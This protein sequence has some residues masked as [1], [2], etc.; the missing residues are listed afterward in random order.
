M[1]TKTTDLKKRRDELRKEEKISL[2]DDMPCNNLDIPFSTIRLPPSRDVITLDGKGPL[3]F[4]H[5]IKV[6]HACAYQ[7][8]MSFLRNEKI[9]A[10]I[11][12]CLEEEKIIIIS[13]DQQDKQMLWTYTGTFTVRA[14]LQW[15]MSSC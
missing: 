1:E 9:L 15:N 4:F 2:L 14:G 3:R 5:I 13:C 12:L 6:R 7:F 8:P 11:N 10:L